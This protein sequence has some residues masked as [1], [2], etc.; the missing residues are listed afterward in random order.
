M[1]DRIFLR[2]LN[3]EEAMKD[4]VK[5]IRNKHFSDSGDRWNLK[6]QHVSKL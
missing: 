4:K 2:E 5:E 3:I 6:N 1:S